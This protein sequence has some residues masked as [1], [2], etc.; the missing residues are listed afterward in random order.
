MCA[1][2]AAYQDILGLSATSMIED[3]V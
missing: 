2:A 1:I 3:A